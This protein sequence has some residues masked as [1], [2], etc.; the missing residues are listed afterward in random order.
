MARALVIDPIQAHALKITAALEER[1]HEVTTITTD[2]VS[3]NLEQSLLQFDLT[4][5]NLTLDRPEDWSLLRRVCQCK[6]M[7]F[8]RF[9]VLAVCSVYRGPQPRLK[10]ERIGC[11]WVYDEQGHSGSGR[12]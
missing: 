2:E 7:D 4:I 11:R 6:P 9:G 12:G 8:R 3:E 5:V 10:A 1:G